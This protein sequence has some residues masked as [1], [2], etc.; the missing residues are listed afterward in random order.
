MKKIL[1]LLSFC[2]VLFS[3]SSEGPQGPQGPPG[4]DGLDGLG[5]T[6]ESTVNL[7]YDAERNYWIT[8]PTIPIPATVNTSEP[9]S[10][11]VLVYRLEVI[12]GTNGDL[13]SWSLIP[14]NF[15]TTEGTI[16]YVYNHTID[17]VEIILDGNYDLSNL[18]TGFTDNQ[19][20]RIVV[21]PS[22]TFAANPNVDLNNYFEVIDAFDIV[23]TEN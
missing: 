19:T 17:D 10:D 20:F 22:A 23:N 6:F 16:Q 12:S 8:N 3:C 9:E 18:D 15:F 13:D 1:T 21:V 14:Q 11:A 4:L 2:F 5:Y 7:E